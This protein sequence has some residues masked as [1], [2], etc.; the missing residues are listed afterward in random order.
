[1]LE[2]KHS[3]DDQFFPHL[4]QSFTSTTIIDGKMASGEYFCKF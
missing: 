1:V 2:V 4:H 3:K